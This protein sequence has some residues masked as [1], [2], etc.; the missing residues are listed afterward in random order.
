MGGEHPIDRLRVHRDEAL[1]PIRPWAAAAGVPVIEGD[2]DAWW[3]H[4]IDL[5]LAASP[6]GPVRRPGRGETPHGIGTCGAGAYVTARCQ[7]R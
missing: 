4:A 3:D 1:D 6:T 2:V 7:R 5:G